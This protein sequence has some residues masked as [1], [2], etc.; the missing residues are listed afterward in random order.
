M[1]LKCIFC[2]E[3]FSRKGNLNKHLGDKRCKVDMIKLHEEVLSLRNNALGNSMIGDSNIQNNITINIEKIEIVNHIGNLDTSYIE[4]EKMKEL[5]DKY[6]KTKLN[7]LLGN[8]IKDIICNKDHPENHAVKYLK[9]KPPT[10]NNLIQDNLNTI[11]GLKDSCELLEAPI[12]EKLKEKLTEYIKDFKEDPNYDRKKAFGIWEELKKGAVKKALSSV[13]QND[14]LND[15][16]MK[17]KPDD[18]LN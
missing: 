11:K 1:T 8:Y 17:F 15:L 5:V 3:E 12:L 16:E 18:I 10:F 7:L 2:N 6:D 4:P 13:L 9:K 14:I